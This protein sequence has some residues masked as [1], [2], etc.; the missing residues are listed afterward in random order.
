M[1]T[2]NFAGS[3]IDRR[4]LMK[5]GAAAGVFASGTALM[6]RAG[7]EI[8]A[9]AQTPEAQSRVA[10]IVAAANAFLATLSDDERSAV[11][12]DF[13]D[14]EQ[15]A[16]WS[17]FPEGLFERDGLMWGNL[18]ET[19]QDAWLALM[20]TTLSEGGY[21]RV[22][23]AW[24]A[25]DYLSEGGGG[26]QGGGPGGMAYG[27]EYYWIA[28]IG[29][30]SESDPWQW[31]W[32]GHHITINATVVGPNLSLNPS[33]IGVQPATY[34]DTDGNEI[35]ALGDI[36]DDAF[37]FL[38]SLDT[39]QLGQAVLGDEY[40][41]LVLGPGPDGRTLQA[42]G[43]PASSL[44]DDQQ[45]LFINLIAHYTGLAND[46]HAAVRLE[47]VT[48][49][50]DDTYFVWYGPTDASGNAYFRV[51]G[52]TIVIEY[53]PQGMGGDPGDHIHGIY[54]DPSNDYGAGYIG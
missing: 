20:Q 50:L 13:S 52:P 41:D 43:L 33:F 8:E 10:G 7:W 49:V 21:T 17:N 1:T 28:I 31:Q 18:S 45:A 34:T 4:H 29:D 30:P 11:L 22:R 39:D 46:E 5:L 51:A 38:S 12:F 2:T 14:D 35:R 9:S 47:E 44:T 23:Q 27:M 42:E 6:T 25:D 54:R 48:S 24:A 26:G 53:S 15:R 19:T 3:K 40:I 36:W 16:R 32:G 37:A